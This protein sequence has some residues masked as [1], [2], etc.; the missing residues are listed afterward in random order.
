[1]KKNKKKKHHGKRGGIKMALNI[2]GEPV[3]IGY[4]EWLIKRDLQEKNKS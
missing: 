2:G 1:M 4:K 3:L